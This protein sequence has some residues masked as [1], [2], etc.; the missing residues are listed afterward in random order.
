MPLQVIHEVVEFLIEKM[1]QEKFSA[2][3]ETIVRG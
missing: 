1:I 2:K 3:F